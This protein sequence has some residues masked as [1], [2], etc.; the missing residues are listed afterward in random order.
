M[1]ALAEF[2]QTPLGQM[3]HGFLHA[4]L[5]KILTALRFEERVLVIGFGVP[6]AAGITALGSDKITLAYLENMPPVPW[7]EAHAHQVCIVSSDALPF[8]DVTFDKVFIVHALETVPDPSHLLYEV[9]RV[10]TAQGQVICIAPNRNGIWSWFEHTPFGEG[11]TF[12]TRQLRR[13]LSSAQ[14]APLNIHTALFMPPLDFSF[15]RFALGFARGLE[16]V[17]QALN[18]RIGGVVIAAA[19]KQRYAGIPVHVHARAKKLRLQWATSNTSSHTPRQ[20]D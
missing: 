13:L 12:S 11:R 20:K 4:Q 2:Y 8:G 3:T 10:L 6:F 9:Q 1:T 15:H 19:Q 16:T 17:C 18:F 14:L 7:P 5:Q